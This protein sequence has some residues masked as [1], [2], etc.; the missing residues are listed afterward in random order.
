[1]PLV[2]AEPQRTRKVN[3]AV[4]V[5]LIAVGMVLLPLVAVIYNEFQ[6]NLLE[7]RVSDDDTV[8]QEQLRV[9]AELDFAD[10]QATLIMQGLAADMGRGPLSNVELVELR[11]V[12]AEL[13]AF[14]ASGASCDTID[15]WF[16]DRYIAD[17]EAF[18]LIVGATVVWSSTDALIK[19]DECSGP[20]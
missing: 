17:V 10:Q 13:D 20:G 9:A 8:S 14:V 19:F 3:G 7:E 11:E 16:R 1:V 12:M 2:E 15:G 6:S 5:V 4:W 18:S